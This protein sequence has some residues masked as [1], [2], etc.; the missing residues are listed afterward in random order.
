MQQKKCTVCG[1]MKDMDQFHIRRSH[2]TGHDSVCK[3]CKSE[4]QT[5]RYH[6]NPEIHKKKSMDWH[7]ENRFKAALLDSRCC[8]RRN[9]TI[10]CSATEQEI[11]LAFHGKCDICG[12]PESELNRK[13]CM[14]HNHD[15]GEFRGWICQHCNKG[16]GNFKD[17]EIVLRNAISYLSDPCDVLLGY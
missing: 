15:T 12:T 17:S 13:L 4:Y 1:E 11:E 10:Q 8:A 6:A 16:L 9:G 2:S 14:D 7:R 5:K 3:I